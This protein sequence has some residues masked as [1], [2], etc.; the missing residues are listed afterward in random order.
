MGRARPG[1]AGIGGDRRDRRD[2]L[3]LGDGQM[4][5]AAD[6]IWPFAWRSHPQA[7][8]RSAIAV[9]EPISLGVTRV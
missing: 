1:S 8:W 6:V 5:L 7:V 2:R 3:S 4:A 9:L